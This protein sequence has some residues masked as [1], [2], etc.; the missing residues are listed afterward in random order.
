[1]LKQ[2]KIILTTALF[3]I[4]ATVSPTYAQNTLPSLLPAC[5]ETGACRI[6]DIVN[7]FV[8]LGRWLIAGAAALALLVI[9]FAASNIVTSAGK[10]EAIA[11]AKKQIVGAV[12]GLGLVLIA[13]QL[14]SF[15]IFALTT[16]A[17]DQNFTTSQ[18]KDTGQNAA[19]NLGNFLGVPWWK[20]CDQAELLE[21][22]S[23]DNGKVPAA[24]STAN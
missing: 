22:G 20:I 1:M 9:V 13:F 15:I 10:S 2:L 6:C 11:G 24:P 5:A 21:K 19:Q 14:V 16:P 4:L 18:G 7:I 12:L 3:G 17:A 23:L 8:T